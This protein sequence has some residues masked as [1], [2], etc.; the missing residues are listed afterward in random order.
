MQLRKSIVALSMTAGLVGGG[1][2]GAV[3]GVP[4]LTGAQED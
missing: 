2:A 1:L 3:L 4:G